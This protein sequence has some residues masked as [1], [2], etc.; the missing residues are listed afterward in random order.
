MPPS[1]VWV[2]RTCFVMMFTP[3]IVTRPVFG[4]TR[5]T[6]P[7]F[8]LSSPESTWTV[9]PF[10]TCMRTRTTGF[11]RTRLAFLCTSGFMLEHLRRERD[12]L[13]VLLL[14]QLARDRAEDA[15][16]ARLARIVDQHGGVLVE[17]DVGAVLAADLLRGADDDRLG[18]VAL[19]HLPGRDGVLDGHH[20]GVAEPGVAALAAAEHADHERAPGAA[21]VR[22]AQYRFL[23]DHGRLGLLGPFNDLGDAPAHGL[24]ERPGLHDAHR[25]PGLGAEVV[26]RLELLGARHLLVVHRVRIAPHHGHGD[27]PLHLVARHQAGP[28]L[29]AATALGGCRLGRAL[30]VA[31]RPCPWAWPARSRRTV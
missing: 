26:S 22:D 31:H 13:H 28:D 16:G 12:D 5:S 9:S 1:A 11:R 7:R 8:P 18:H 17:P 23:L 4:N 27:R 6:L 25:V 14:P 19:L 2:A 30:L 20:H 21:V 15:C 10:V 29:P 3:S 24:R